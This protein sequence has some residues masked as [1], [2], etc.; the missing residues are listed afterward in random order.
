MTVLEEFSNDSEKFEY[1]QS[2]QR[3]QMAELSV[4]AEHRQIRED[5][6]QAI[7]KLDETSAKLDETSC[8]LDEKS[9]QLMT[10]AKT[11]IAS[12]TMTLDQIA[13]ATGMSIVEINKLVNE[14]D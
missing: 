12:N 1:Y 8:L 14:K 3:I 7:N 2:R 11:L 9:S 10:L 13:D 6:Q 5:Y 4:E